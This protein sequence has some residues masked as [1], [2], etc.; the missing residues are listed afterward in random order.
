MNKPLLSKSRF[1]NL[2][3]LVRPPEC[4]WY[5]ALLAND[6]FELSDEQRMELSEAI[7]LMFRYLTKTLTEEDKKLLRER[8]KEA[9]EEINSV[10]TFKWY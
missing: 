7:W 3:Q 8:N 4:Q 10:T 1:T 2:I 5:N 9:F 6:K